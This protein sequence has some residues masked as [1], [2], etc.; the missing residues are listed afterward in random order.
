[1]FGDSWVIFWIKWKYFF[2]HASVSSTYPCQ[3]AGKSVDDSFGFPFCQ[4]LWDLTKRRDDIAVADMVADISADMEVHMVADMGVDKVADM[5]ADMEVD[6]VADKVV[7]MVADMVFLVGGSNKKCWR[8]ISFKKDSS[9]DHPVLFGFCWL[10]KANVVG[11]NRTSTCAKM[12]QSDFGQR[13]LV[14]PRSSYRCSR[15][16]V[17]FRRWRWQIIFGDVLCWL[18]IVHFVWCLVQIV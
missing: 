7:D 10:W 18:S 5:V 2:R 8:T 3:Y 17:W 14:F 6:K 9:R 16:C 13:T 1:M 11:A 12:V 4:R 15:D